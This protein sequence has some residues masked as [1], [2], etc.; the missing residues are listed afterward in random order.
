MKQGYKWPI[1][2]VQKAKEKTSNN[3]STTKTTEKTSNTMTN[4][5]ESEKRIS[6]IYNKLLNTKIMWYM[7]YITD[8][9]KAIKNS[10]KYKPQEK[11]KKNLIEK[12]LKLEK[13]TKYLMLAL[14]WNVEANIKLPDYI[15][16]D[17][18]Q[19]FWNDTKE[20]R[21]K[22]ELKYINKKLEKIANDYWLKKILPIQKKEDLNKILTTVNT[23]LGQDNVMP[24]IHII[25]QAEKIQVN[26]FLYPNDFLYEHYWLFNKNDFVELNNFIWKDRLLYQFVIDMIKEDLDKEKISQEDFDKYILPIIQK[27][28]KLPSVKE[29]AKLFDDDNTISE[30]ILRILRN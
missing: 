25:K 13:E 10:N 8:K 20:N 22:A 24:I 9:Y 27:I 2:I 5:L 29:Q 26:K 1:R 12:Y 19:V 21:E 11:F 7:W 4:L 15:D 14:T 23:K 3:N 17:E 30:D 28:K 18:K 16:Y 6:D